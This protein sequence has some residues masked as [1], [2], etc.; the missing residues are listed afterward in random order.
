M[1]NND[2][3]ENK[4]IDKVLVN[5]T[6][7]VNYMRKSDTLT[8][9]LPKNMIIMLFIY[10][11]MIL[12]GGGGA[13]IKIACGLMSELSRKEILRSAFLIS[14]AVSGMLCSVQYIKRLYKACLTERIDF[15]QNTKKIIGN[16]AYFICRP[17][18]AFAFSTIMVFALLSGMFVVTGNLDYILNEKFVYLCTIMSSFLG[19]SIGNLLDK[20]EKLSEDKISNIM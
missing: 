13:A 10:Y 4:N 17:F 7:A 20:F 8:Y 6:E 14:I 3:I 9:D 2:T 19:Y 1:E 15:S 18:F 11:L 16:M 5:T 12:I